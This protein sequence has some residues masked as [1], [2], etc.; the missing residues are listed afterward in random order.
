MG[1][2]APVW[3]ALI[4]AVALLGGCS[5]TS[6]GSTPSTGSPPSAATSAATTRAAKHHRKHRKVVRHQHRAKTHR[7][8]Q[9]APPAVPSVDMPNHSL[10][11]GVAYAVTT[12]RICTP[13]YAESVRDVPESEK[14]AVY[15]RYGVVDVPYAH[16]VDHLISLEIGGSNS[17][18]NLWPEP[19]AGKWGARTK[20][21]VENALHDL[22]CSG[23]L[24]LKA[25]QRIEASN[26]VAA[27]K[28]YVSPVPLAHSR[29]SYGGG[30]GTGSTGSTSAG[31]YY[32]SSFPSA[33]TIYCADDAEWRSLSKTYL[34][35]FPTLAAALKR[36]PGRHLHRPC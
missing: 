5:S 12:A 6:A 25:A 19:Y 20:D 29:Y 17:I 18:R 27:Y 10:T 23:R 22:V 9:P 35:H 3:I 15:D 11:P 21:Q 13:G 7:R 34:V 24:G 1:N 28:R 31:G 2:P 14:H 26:W 4:A 33:Y 36:F 30:G 32:A 16:E 8:T